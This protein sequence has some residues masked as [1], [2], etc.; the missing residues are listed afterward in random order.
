M[1]RLRAT[2]PSSSTTEPH[3][4]ATLK[5][6]SG[7]LFFSTFLGMFFSYQLFALGFLP[8]GYY[9]TVTLLNGFNINFE[10]E[11]A[12]PWDQNL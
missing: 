10:L 9:A 7:K 5:P 8:S 1:G 4:C 11:L 6:L 12:F 3:S 2:I